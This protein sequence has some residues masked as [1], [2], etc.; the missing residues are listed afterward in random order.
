MQREKEY[1]SLEDVAET[2][3]V[4]YQ[5]IYKLVRAGELPASRL[6]KLYRVSRKDLEEYLERTKQ[7]TA[8]GGACAACGKVYESRLSLRQQCTETECDEPICIDCWNRRGIRHCRTH[9]P[10]KSQK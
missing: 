4:T 2:L 1:L 3:G 7:P 5:L 8:S 9:E 6:G 10:K